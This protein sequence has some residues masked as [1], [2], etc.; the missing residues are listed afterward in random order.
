MPPSLAS[1]ALRA[2]STPMTN[3]PRGLRAIL[4]SA[5]LATLLVAC[6]GGGGGG[7]PA[8]APASTPGAAATD[9]T[10]AGSSS[11][12]PTLP[13]AASAAAPACANCAAVDANTYA[14]S[15]VGIWQKTNSGSV[16]MDVPVSI[17]GLTG[18]DVTLVFTNE[19]ATAVPLPA[20]NQGTPPARALLSKDLSMQAAGGTTDAQAAIR[21]FNR[22]GWAERIAQANP[23]GVI[24]RSLVTPAPLTAVHAV[25]ATR[26]FYLDNQDSR[27]ATLQ[28]Q[29]ATS[30]GT[31]VNVWVE[32]AEIG[33]AKVTVPMADQLATSFAKAG[34]IYDMVKTAGGPLWGPHN[35]AGLIPGSGQPVDIVVLNFDRDRTPYGVVGFFWALHQLQ[36]SVDSRSNEST[37]LYLDAETLYLGG[38]RGAKMVQMTMAH[39]AMHMGNFYRRGVLMG[40]QYQ[41]ET[42]LEE[43]TAMMMEDAAASAIDATYNPLRDVRL[44]DY[45]GYGSYNCALQDWT[46]FA[47]CE[48]YAVSGSLGGF[49]LRQLGIGFF[50]GLLQQ[51]QAD[52]VAALDGAIQAARPGSGLGQQLRN[53]AATAIG[54]L[55]LSAPA[56]FGFP[57]RNEAGFAVPAVDASQLKAQRTLP[58]ASPA[59]LAAYA[60]HPVVRPAVKG[61][62]AETVRVPP[63]ATLSVVV[64]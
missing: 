21:E 35:V 29:L 26:S 47:A 40:A 48:S 32:S 42:W 56:S 24:R 15:G 34:G 2:R 54:T 23:E 50:Q 37:S 43:M 9:A 4:G 7:D 16:A 31:K 53:F 30:D 5:L 27:T 22:K 63:G 61:T 36:R 14:G 33:A 39:E 10:S 6:G 51:R 17:A 38:Q 59:S 64:H 18:Q 60:H 41:Y 46:P 11:P 58:T 44:Q 1:A 62:F 28:R 19:A 45:L 55:P 52:S 8:V 25:G 3:H 13:A 12:V 57:A 20:I 49:L